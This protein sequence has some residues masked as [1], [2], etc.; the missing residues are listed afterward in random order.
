MKIFCGGAGQEVG[1]SHFVIEQDGFRVGLDA[2]IKIIEDR[3]IEYPILQD[4]IK[5]LVLTHAHMDHS[6]YVP[7]LDKS[8]PVYMTK[9]TLLASEHMW[10]D[11]IKVARK[12]NRPPDYTPRDIRRVLRDAEILDY[13][14]W[15]ASYGVR[16]KMLRAGHLLGASMVYLE[17]GGKR[18]LYTGDFKYQDTELIRRAEPPPQVDILIIESTYWYQN[19]PDRRSQ[20]QRIYEV[21]DRTIDMGGVA[22]FP[23]FSLGRTQDLI[24]ILV[25]RYK[26]RVPI[27][28][29]GLGKKINLVY[30]SFRDELI[31]RG[32][33]KKLDEIDEIDG[34]KRRSKILDQPGIIISSSGMLEGGPA[35][36]YVFNLNKNSSII[37]T[38]YQIRGSNG[39]RLIN[40]NKIKM[41]DVEL[42]VDLPVYHISISAHGDRGDIMEFIQRSSPEKIVLVHSDSSNIFQEELRTE[43]GY[44]VFSPT[45]GQWLDL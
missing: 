27:Y 33:L 38:G 19:H 4:N 45:T 42:R 18:I 28:V 30:R 26:N 12:R 3:G 24:S 10:I 34:M 41:N 36:Y 1:R 20:I 14:E 5:F 15:G 39:Y 13:G 31:D 25:D 17:M 32:F 43:H 37:L 21:V 29:D 16:F 44:Q 22:L 7:A 11:A 40:Y 2:G 9:P 35:L 8:I 23:A 6:G